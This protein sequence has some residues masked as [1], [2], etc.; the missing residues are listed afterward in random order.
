MAKQKV[1]SSW[2]IP[3][4]Y[5]AALEAVFQHKRVMK[6]HQVELAIRGY[7]ENEH[8]DVLKKEKINL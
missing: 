4:E 6:S 2:Y 7:M 3:P 1:K 5:A 8:K